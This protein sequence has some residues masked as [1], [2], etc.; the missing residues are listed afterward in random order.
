MAE[1]KAAMNLRPAVIPAFVGMTEEGDDRHLSKV[2]RVTESP[3][4]GPPCGAWYR[5][6]PINAQ[7]GSRASPV[8]KGVRALSVTGRSSISMCLCFSLVSS[9]EVQPRG[10]NRV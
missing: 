1:T 7:R 8:V 6:E 2:S 9:G 4:P 3:W 5:S 10:A